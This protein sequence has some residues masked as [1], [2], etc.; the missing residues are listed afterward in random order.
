[1]QPFAEGSSLRPMNVFSSQVAKRNER[2]ESYRHDHLPRPLKVQVIN[3]FVEIA[4]CLPE[5]QR[6]GY[7]VFFSVVHR[8]L[9]EEYGFS[10]LA[11]QP[12]SP[13][14]DLFQFFLKESNASKGLHVIKI[15]FECFVDIVRENAN[16]HPD[17]MRHHHRFVEKLNARLKEYSVGY[18][19]RE[20]RFQPVDSGYVRQEILAPTMA[21]L[22]ERYL[23]GANAEFLRAHEYYGQGR[24]GDSIDECLKAFESTL[25]AICHKRKWSYS[26]TDT[27]RTLL[28]LGERKGLFPAFMQATFS[29]LRSVLENVARPRHQL[30]GHHPGVHPAQI[31]SEMVAFGLHSTAVHIQFLVALEKGMPPSE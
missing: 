13:A 23:D 27:V 10:D 24:F 1:L 8:V 17:G 11:P 28:A 20:G 3:V 26:P 9:R 4:L 29:G 5:V 22:H 19:F 2:V 31:T 12:N 30:S 15:V 7:D 16:I 21:L 18:E 6:K 14:E 25:K